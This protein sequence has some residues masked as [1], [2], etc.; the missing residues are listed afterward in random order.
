MAAIEAQRR[1]ALTLSAEWSQAGR[2]PNL[3][4]VPTKTS[5]TLAT[6]CMRRPSWCSLGGMTNSPRTITAPEGGVPLAPVTTDCITAIRQ[7]GTAVEHPLLLDHATFTVGSGSSCD[8]SIASEYVSSRHCLLERRGSRLR[9]HDQT[10]RNGTFRRG[11]RETIF[12]VEAGDTFKVATTALLAVNEIMRTNRVVLAELLGYDSEAILDDA[13]I[14]AIQDG[15]LLI[16]GP[17]GGRLP[18]LTRA[19]HETSP[20]RDHPLVEVPM[21]PTSREEQK[22]LVAST[23][24]GTLVVTVRGQPMDNAF[25]DLVMDPDALIRLVVVAPSLEAAQTMRLHALTRMTQILVRPL[26]ER[27]NDVGRLFDNLFFEKR[28]TERFANLTLENQAALRDYAWPRNLDELHETA[29]WMSTII[30]EGSVRKAAVVLEVPRTTFQYWLERVNLSLPLIR[31]Y[32]PWDLSAT[33][34]LPDGKG[35]R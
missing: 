6:P 18:Q 22:H 1:A 24:R 31:Q 4:S 17:D 34:R 12:D 35:R 27:R 21:V 9:V 7:Y 2:I 30:R 19:I 5:G 13:L 29:A 8:V 14:A 3:A 26:R 32:G 23:R 16:L 20:R 11:R 28:L 10:S 15:P 25:F 33:V